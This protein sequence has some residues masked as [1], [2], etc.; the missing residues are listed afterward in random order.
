MKFPEPRAHLGN[1]HLRKNML[2]GSYVCCLLYICVIDITSCSN[3]I[4]L[5]HRIIDTPDV[6]PTDDITQ[7]ERTVTTVI[8]QW[9]EPNYYNAPIKMYTL[10]LC[11]KL[12]HDNCTSVNGYPLNI[13]A[14]E[15]TNASIVR[16][17]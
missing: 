13:T 15:Y 5:I 1:S 17:G 16:Y 14:D 11:Q 2:F 12:L 3:M 9:K 10:N 4:C 8:V 7:P 6:I